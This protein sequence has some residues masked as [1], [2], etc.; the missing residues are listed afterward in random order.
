MGK[1]VD[2]SQATIG[3]KF[4]HRPRFKGK[5]S[6][7][8]HNTPVYRRFLTINKTVAGFPK[9]IPDS[10][11]QIEKVVGLAHPQIQKRTYTALPIY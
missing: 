9:G 10:R 3:S 2:H 5:D 4:Q 7:L 8:I 1:F 6:L 11:S